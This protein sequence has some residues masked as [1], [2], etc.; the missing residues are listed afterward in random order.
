MRYCKRA[1]KGTFAHAE[2]MRETPT[3]TEDALWQRLRAWRI[4]FKFN[5]QAV[6]LGWIADFYCAAAKLIIEVDGGYHTSPQQRRRDAIRDASMRVKGFLVLRFRVAA[7][8]SQLDTVV[9]V[10]RLTATGRSK[11]PPR[12]RRRHPASSRLSLAETADKRRGKDYGVIDT[13]LP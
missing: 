5:R 6:V 1:K 13:S 12:G 2:R 11:A 3:A 10:I 8:Q 4:G 7:I 9:E